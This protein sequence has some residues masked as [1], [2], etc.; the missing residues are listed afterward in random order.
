MT[1][2]GSVD[3]GYG[4]EYG[5]RFRVPSSED[6]DE[7][8]MDDIAGPDFHKP[9]EAGTSIP[10]TSGQQ[11]HTRASKEW[12]ISLGSSTCISLPCC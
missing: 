1:F 8:R 12:V 6:G 2:S 3:V 7:S 4:L 11:E 9:S 5:S 10:T